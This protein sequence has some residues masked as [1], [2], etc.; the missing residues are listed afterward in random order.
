MKRSQD[1]VPSS[2][3]QSFSPQHKKPKVAGN[4]ANLQADEDGA[5]SDWTRVER[6]KA[7]KAKKVEAKH[8]VCRCVVVPPFEYD[9]WFSCL[10]SG[11]DAT[12]HVCER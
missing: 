10:I 12:I 4:T 3:Q 5:N 11:A 6:R 8:D 2:P 1:Y 9:A 7:R